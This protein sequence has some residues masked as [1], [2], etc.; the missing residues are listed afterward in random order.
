MKSLFTI[1]LA[2]GVSFGLAQTNI[3]LHVE[4]IPSQNSKKVF[5]EAFEKDQWQILANVE[6]DATANVLITFSPSHEGQYRLRF[7][8]VGKSWTDFYINPQT[9]IGR[10][11]V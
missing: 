10:A 3:K 6:L 9:E 4:N 5:L 8:G 2:L 7:S 11:H 1:I